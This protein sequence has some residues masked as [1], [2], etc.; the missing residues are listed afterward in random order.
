VLKYSNSTCST[1]SKPTIL[2]NYDTALRIVGLR[3]KGN[4]LT[5]IRLNIS[6][7]IMVVS[8]FLNSSFERHWSVVV[9]IFRFIKG[10][11]RKELVYMYMS[12]TYTISYSYAYIIR[13]RMLAACDPLQVIIFYRRK[14][15]L[16][17][18]H[19][20]KYYA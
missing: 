10:L 12:H 4:Y 9:Q 15:Y 2:E 1:I 20:I 5:K 16:V 6:F 11:L 3:Q 13:Q 14:P 18:E 17:E 7:C 19:K 8:Q